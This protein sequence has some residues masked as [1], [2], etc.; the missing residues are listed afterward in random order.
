ML[1]A[2]LTGDVVNSTLLPATEEQRLVKMLEGF[3]APYVFEF[4]RGD[5]F[6]VYI[7][8]AAHALE[9]ALLCR[10]AA[11]SMGTVE[12]DFLPDIRLSIGIG[13]VAKPVIPL[14]L[15]KG[16]AFLLSGRALDGLEKTGRRLLLVSAPPI[17]ALALLLI[18]DH[19]D[20]IYKEMTAKQAEVILELIK[21]NTQQQAAEKLSR[22]KSTVSQHVTAGR[23]NEIENL[24]A[25]YKKLIEL[26]SA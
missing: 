13:A 21:G 6:Q 10:T 12:N 2:V 25:H 1:H 24:L 3:L 20:A 11:L 5:S 4:Y 18:A 15:A 14:G 23:W 16:E 17:P 9:L 22:S 19:L 7:E 8:D 26:M